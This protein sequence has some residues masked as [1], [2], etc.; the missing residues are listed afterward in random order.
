MKKIEK[1]EYV[2]DRKEVFTPSLTFVTVPSGIHKLHGGT[3]ISA[4]HAA[5]VDDMYIMFV[6]FSH[7]TET[8]N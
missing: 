1:P 5:I 4:G 3:E 7:H 2:P 6:L 8:T